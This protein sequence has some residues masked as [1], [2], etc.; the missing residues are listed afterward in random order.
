[1]NQSNKISLIR[2]SINAKIYNLMTEFKASRSGHLC[3]VLPEPVDSALL[4]ALR[5]TGSSLHS[6]ILPPGRCCEISSI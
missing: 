6:A 3:F 5:V 4:S 1:V 2:N